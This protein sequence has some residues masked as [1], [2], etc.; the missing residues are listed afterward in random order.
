MIKFGA[1]ASQWG[2]SELIRAQYGKSTQTE[3]LLQNVK[4]PKIPNLAKFV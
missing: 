1:F 2:Q 4:A 3:D